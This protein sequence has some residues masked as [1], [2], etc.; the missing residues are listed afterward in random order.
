MTTTRPVLR[1][2]GITPGGRPYVIR[3]SEEGDAPGLAALID[4]VAGEG[5]LIAAV[6][7]EPDTIEQSSRLVSIVLEGG[8]TLTLEVDGVP[9]GHVMVQRRAGRHYAHVGE[10]AIL[11]S[12]SQRG[13]GLGRALL[14]MAI[15]WGQAVGLAKLTLRVFPD[16][17]RAIG[18]Y[19]ALGFRDEGLVKGEVRMPSGDRDMLLMGLA[20]PGLR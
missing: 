18:L 12:N 17:Q 9:A 19:R 2:E 3:P 5:E 13:L 4:E 11:V 14:E 8:L 1:R 15:A 20:L 7:G 10:I 16:N 6:P